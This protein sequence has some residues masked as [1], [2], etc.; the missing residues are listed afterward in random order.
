MESEK[1]KVLY[2][3]PFDIEILE[4]MGQA[5]WEKLRPFSPIDMV[6]QGRAQA[7]GWFRGTEG[8]CQARGWCL[9]QL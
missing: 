7:G 9:S 2:R 6:R 3:L 5:L 1:D 8:R 4:G